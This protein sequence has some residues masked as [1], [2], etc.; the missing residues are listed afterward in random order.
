M[1]TGYKTYIVCAVAIIYA[2][3]GFYTGNLDLNTAFQVVL[4]ALGAAGLRHGIST[5][6]A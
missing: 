6:T 3:S 4:A 2:V 1:L 5:P